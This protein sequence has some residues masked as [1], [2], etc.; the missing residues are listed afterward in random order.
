MIMITN[1]DDDENGAITMTRSYGMNE[2]MT[3]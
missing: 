2:L 1:D 3:L